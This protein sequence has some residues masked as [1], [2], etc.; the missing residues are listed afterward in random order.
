MKDTEHNIQS[1]IIDYL[2]KKGIF[3][4]RNNSGAVKTEDRFVRYGTPGSPDIICVIS[5]RYV[6]IEVKTDT[7]RQNASQKAFQESLLACGGIYFLV[8]N[9]DEAMEAIEDCITRLRLLDKQVIG[10]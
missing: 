7:G 3:H 9:I 1:S 8:H 4:Y 6:G 10:R 2:S 5:G